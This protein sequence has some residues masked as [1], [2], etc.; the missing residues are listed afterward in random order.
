MKDIKAIFCD[1]DGTLLTSK[2]AAADST[3]KVVKKLKESGILF[4]VAT[5]R[6]VESSEA[7]YASWGIDGI[8]DMF[9]GYNGG[10]L[11]DY[12][13]NVFEEIHPL[14]GETIRCIIDT[15]DDLNVNFCC[16]VN[17]KV[18]L[19][20][21]DVPGRR[22][23]EKDHLSFGFMSKD[24][25]CSQAR[26]KIMIICEESM[27][28]KVIERGKLTS[29]NQYNSMRTAPFLYEFINSNI[30][31]ASGLKRIME[32]RGWNIDNLMVFG[33]ED[34]D[35]EMI[36]ESGVGVAMRNGCDRVKNIADYITDYDN[37][38]DGIADFLS[39]YFK[40]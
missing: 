14:S 12:E 40:L 33:D 20:K 16:T 21:D 19:L 31:K 22:M 8:V 34:N 6:E 11:K 35:Y 18:M 30:S 24:E 28:D 7:K 5:G 27:M 25:M 37:N 13:L 32:K 1:L 23:C 9:V 36:S 2:D 3:I 29:S 39:K 26:G 38:H 4:G 10:Q 17:T 15:F